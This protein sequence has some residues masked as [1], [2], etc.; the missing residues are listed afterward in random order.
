MSQNQMLKNLQVQIISPN[1]VV[2]TKRALKCH[3]QTIS[4]GTTILPNHIAMMTALDISAVVVTPLN[5]PEQDDYIA[6]DGGLLEVRANELN[7]IS[8]MAIRARDIDDA[9]QQI[10][11]SLAEDALKQAKINQDIRA[12]H[13]A[14]I[15]VRKALNLLKVVQHRQN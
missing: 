11:L 1:G 12:Y 3:V 6:V 5:N 13:T 7:I 2:Y 15:Q 10:E 4:G 14:E 8:N 9:Q